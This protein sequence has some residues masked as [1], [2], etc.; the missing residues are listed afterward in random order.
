M[1]SQLTDRTKYPHV[2]AEIERRQGRALALVE[3]KGS[4]VLRILQVGAF[5]DPRPWFEPGTIDGKYWLISV[6]NYLSL[7]IDVARHIK[8]C[9]KEVTYE[10]DE[11]GNV[12]AVPTGMLKIQLTD[13][14]TL[15]AICSKAMLGD[16]VNVSGT[17]LQLNWADMQRKLESGETLPPISDPIEAQILSI[18][19]RGMSVVVPGE[20]LPLSA[21][22]E[23][24]SDSPTS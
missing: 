13:K 11:D 14:E 16:K 1:G 21:P 12:C 10:E 4:D 22:H 18:A 15:I 8:Y 5:L 17:I 24:Q 2:V 6:E 20:S 7:P 9:E 19:D 3:Q 23:S